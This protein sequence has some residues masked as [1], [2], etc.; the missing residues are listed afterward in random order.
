MFIVVSAQAQGVKPDSDQEA[1]N[2]KL[3]EQFAKGNRWA[4]L[5]GVDG[6]ANNPLVGP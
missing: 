4:I 6:Y 2:R 1:W 3:S 5:I